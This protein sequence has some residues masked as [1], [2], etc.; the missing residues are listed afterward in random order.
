MHFNKNQP[1]TVSDELIAIIGDPSKTHLQRQNACQRLYERHTSWV[2]HE[3]SKR[4]FSQDDV[5]DIAQN[6]W[7]QVLQPDSLTKSYKSREGKF[8]AYLR[9]PIKWAILKHIDKLPF[10]IDEDGAKS[11]PEFTNHEL[12]LSDEV[13][14]KGVDDWVMSE[15]IENIIKPNLP[16]VGLKSRNVYVAN[17][18]ETIFSTD[19]SISEVAAIN[20]M[21]DSEANRLAREAFGKSVAACSDQ[22]IAVYLPLEYRSLVDTTELEKS[23]GRYLA[24]M[25]GIT[26]GVFRKRLHTARK[27]LLEIV[28][29]N[30]NT[31][32]GGE[33]G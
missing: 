6:V 12:S 17:E 3:I 10:T 30:F 13:F 27:Y 11:A 32:N 20:D 18:F 16:S 33:H 15:V 23:S 8:R 25:M 4:V 31:A 2:V 24:N 14:D 22:E 28:R 5:Q 21:S 19:P 1:D 26:E 29:Q 9:Q 7:M